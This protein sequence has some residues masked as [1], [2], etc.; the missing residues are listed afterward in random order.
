MH[1]AQ[2][3]D[4]RISSSIAVVLIA[5]TCLLLVLTMSEGPVVKNPH[6]AHIPERI[7]ISGAYV[8]LEPL[9]EEHDESLYE[10]IGNESKHDLWRYIPKGPFSTLEGYKGQLNEFRQSQSSQFY[11]IVCNKTKELL[12]SIGLISIH[13]E[14]RT[15]EI[16]YVMFSQK[17]QR[18]CAGTDT[19][20]LLLRTAFD[21]HQYRR[22]EWKCNNLNE[23][24]KSAAQRYGFVFEGVFRQH[25]IIR[26]RNRDTAWFSIIDSD[27]PIRK[28]AFEAWL[29]PSN[30]DEEGKQKASLAQL[31]TMSSKT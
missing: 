30:F 2:E 16:G 7:A 18:T 5:R 20:Y 9:A 8:T 22:V 29:T 10:L 12:G 21:T 6:P 1:A 27:W 26:G 3:N 28:A 31:R 17:M 25:Y 24:S 11:V 23:K 15:M 13:P 19:I 4:S 14:H